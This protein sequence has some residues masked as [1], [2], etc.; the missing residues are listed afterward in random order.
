MAVTPAE[1][2]RIAALRRRMAQ[3][4]PVVMLNPDTADPG[5]ILDLVGH[6]FWEIFLDVESGTIGPDA[7][8]RLC[9]LLRGAGALPLVRPA[10][11]DPA[12]IAACL[13]AGALGIVAPGIESV[14]DADELARTVAAFGSAEASPLALG[15]LESVLILN[16]IPRLARVG[17]IDAYMIGPRD[18]GRS[19]S[20]PLGPGDPQVRATVISLLGQLSREGKAAGTPARP[21]TRDELA[22]AGCSVFYIH[23]DGLG[24]ADF[25]ALAALAQV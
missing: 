25:A 1:A 16:E 8:P 3:R 11:N 23:A 14:E 12:D 9:G 17:G 5:R 13:E 20:P 19:M 4:L 7:L 15:I 24:A 21:E 22:A 18:L 10:T 6:G 2:A